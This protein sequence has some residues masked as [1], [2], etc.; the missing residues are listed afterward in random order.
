[1][2]PVQVQ[3]QVRESMCNGTLRIP[4]WSTRLQLCLDVSV[5]RWRRQALSKQAEANYA[6][7]DSSP[8]GDRDWLVSVSSHIDADKLVAVSS[9]VGLLVADARRLA[10]QADGGGSDDEPELLA[11]P[12]DRA[13]LFRVLVDVIQS[14]T[15]VPAA[16]G[17]NKANLEDKVSALFYSIWL[18][19]GSER[20]QTFLDSVVSVTTD[21]G[22]ESGI[23]EFNAL[24]VQSL[25]PE[26]VTRAAIEPDGEQGC[27]SGV[28]LAY[29]AGGAVGFVF[30]N[31]LPVSGILH[32][33]A[34]LSSQARRVFI[35]IIIGITVVIISGQKRS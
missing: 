8:Q 14:R 31:A 6:F 24:S 34:C 10:L 2:L 13:A 22:V 30:I 12:L 11:P 27:R 16:L 26:W 33:P 25:L 18:E 29:A 3:T 35:V 20:I 5:M 23:S 1:M 4:H 15:C 21:L 32:I 19:T 7:A 17:L 28:N 9:A